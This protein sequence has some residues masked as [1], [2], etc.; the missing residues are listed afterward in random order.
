[1]EMRKI[2]Y[3]RI[4]IVLMTL[5][6][7]VC[8]FTSIVAAPLKTAYIAQGE[9]AG[10][11][12]P[13]NGWKTCAPEAV[14]MNAQKLSKAIEYAA[15]SELNTEGIVVI[16]DGYIIAESYFGYFEQ[17]DTHESNSM[18]KGFSSALIGIAIDKGLISGVDE[19]LC[20][21]YEAWDC[22]NKD[23]LRSKL[24]LRHAMTLTTGLEWNED[25]SGEWDFETN[26]ALKMSLNGYYMQYMSDR[27]GLHEPG[28]KF[29]YSTGDPMLLTKV[30]QDATGMTAFDFAQQEIFKPLNFTD[31]SWRKG[32]GGYTATAFGL[33]AT[34]RDYAKFGYLFMNKGKWEDRQIVSEK[35]VKQ[36][37]SPD[38]SV[39]GWGELYGYLWHINL[40]KRLRLKGMT[41]STDTIP[42][43]AYMAKGVKGQNIFIIPSKDLII[44]KVASQKKVRMDEAKFLKMVIAAEKG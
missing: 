3:A 22:D 38:F 4:I 44:V 25:W 16:K 18:A 37:T 43:D 34:V 13:T 19:K 23:D 24:T 39:N 35:W 2:G 10:P 26:D 33:Q 17:E 11:Y 12:W 6:F 27:K 21:Y 29:F 32:T 20:K 1:M 14:G 36:S 7:I 31:V 41:T 15:S 30:I 8:S 42:A 5:T 9:Y 40:P 28:E